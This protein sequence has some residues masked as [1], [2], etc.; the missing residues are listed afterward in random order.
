MSAFL[1]HFLAQHPHAGRLRKRRDRRLGAMTASRPNMTAYAAALI[2]NVV[3]PLRAAGLE[4]VHALRDQWPAPR[5]A[6]DRVRAADADPPRTIRHEVGRVRVDVQP[7]VRGAAPA[8]AGKAISA[9]I[10]HVDKKLGAKVKAS[11]GIEIRQAVLRDQAPL[12]AAVD[13]ARRENIELIESISEDYFD[14]LE[15]VLADNWENNGDWSDAVDDVMHLGEVTQSRAELI[16]RDQTLKMNSR[17]NEARQRSLGIK[18]Y[19][20]TTVGDDRVREAHRELEGKTI[21]YDD[22]PTD[23]DGNTGHA[24]DCGVGDRCTQDPKFDADEPEEEDDEDVAEVD[25]GDED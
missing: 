23:S 4:A 19:V 13:V 11:L 10:G 6:G 8:L 16:A 25:E 9:N 1:R 17:F 15:K 21:D 2:W 12:A 7:K 18:Q 20:W 3:K 5:E 14:R 22:P 24:G